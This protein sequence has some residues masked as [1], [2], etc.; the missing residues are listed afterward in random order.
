MSINR[1]FDD[2]NYSLLCIYFQKQTITQVLWN[3]PFVNLGTGNSALEMELGLELE[4]ELILQT[5][6][7]LVPLGLWTPNLGGWWFRMRGPHP[8]SHEILRYRGHV[9]NKKRYISNF[10]RPMDPKL[11]RVV[12]Y[13]E[14]TSPAK[15]HRSHRS[16]GHVSSQNISSPHSQGPRSPKL[17]RLLN[18]DERA[19]PKK[20]WSREKSKPSYFLNHRVVEM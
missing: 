17:G 14:K 15:S 3:K 20:S 6:L 19:P 4:L 10:T 7:F 18:Q 1:S 16:G 8:Q 5:P 9:T 13:D 12:T 2:I 11:S